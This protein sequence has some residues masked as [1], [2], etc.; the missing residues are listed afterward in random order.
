M[1]SLLITTR[2]GAREAKQKGAE[3]PLAWLREL[4]PTV[5][6]YR[7]TPGGRNR[8][9]AQSSCLSLRMTHCSIYRQVAVDKCKPDSRIGSF[10]P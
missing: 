8:N 9:Q 4:L 7:H 10:L 6:S 1:S 3:A 5:R 2:R